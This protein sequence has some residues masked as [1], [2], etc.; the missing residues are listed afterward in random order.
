MRTGIANEVAMGSLRDE[1]WG[2]KNKSRATLAFYGVGGGP[3]L[4]GN[5]AGADGVDTEVAGETPTTAAE[6]DPL[7]HFRKASGGR[8]KR[9]HGPN[10]GEAELSL[11]RLSYGRSSTGTRSSR[12]GSFHP[13][14]PNNG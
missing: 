11:V 14:T 8:V 12:G 10:I 2:G 6:G 1:M 5:S 7:L 4:G 3:A 9:Q 13:W